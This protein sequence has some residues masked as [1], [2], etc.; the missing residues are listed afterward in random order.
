MLLESE[1]R[2]CPNVSKDTKWTTIKESMRESKRTCSN[3]FKFSARTH[4]LSVEGKRIDVMEN[5]RVTHFI[6]SDGNIGLNRSR[7]HN[8]PNLAALAKQN[9][10]RLEQDNC[11]M[12]IE[13]GLPRNGNKDDRNTANENLQTPR[14]K[15][16]ERLT[17][18]KKKEREQQDGMS[19][20][21]RLTF[22]PCDHCGLTNHPTVK[23]WRNPN[24]ESYNKYN[25]YSGGSQNS[26]I[27][28]NILNNHLHLNSESHVQNTKSTHLK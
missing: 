17:G 7:E 22:P 2:T 16:P 26:R 15:I 14:H 3:V 12:A 10:T 18:K 8:C 4:N 9:K 6:V 5:R 27:Y 20:T 11:H 19:N 21:G 13:M 25:T 28:K 24:N 1:M 23:C